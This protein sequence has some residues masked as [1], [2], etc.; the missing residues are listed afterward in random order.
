[1]DDNKKRAL[2]LQTLYK[3]ECAGHHYAANGLK[4][5][6]ELLAKVTELQK[7]EAVT[8]DYEKEQAEQ[9]DKDRREMSAL[10][11]NVAVADLSGGNAAERRQNVV[12]ALGGDGA[13]GPSS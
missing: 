1:M 6:E 9:R 4:E 7:Q 12:G 13:S 5:A 11:G 10:L 8:A 2:Y 3:G